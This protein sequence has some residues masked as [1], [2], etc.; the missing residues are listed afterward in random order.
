MRAVDQYRRVLEADREMHKSNKIF[1][2]DLVEQVLQW[3]IGG[4]NAILCGDFN[5]NAYMDKLARRLAEPDIGMKEQ[6]FN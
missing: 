5:Q 3:K 4:S 2:E 6:V 1:Q